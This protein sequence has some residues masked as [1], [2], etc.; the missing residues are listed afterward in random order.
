MTCKHCHTWN[1][2]DEP[3]CVRCSR[4]LQDARPRPAPETYPLATATAPALESLQRREAQLVAVPAGPQVQAHHQPSLFGSPKVIP[5]PRLIPVRSAPRHSRSNEDLHAV[6]SGPRNA[7]RSVPRRGND[8]QQSLDFLSSRDLAGTMTESAAGMPPETVI[9]CNA[10]VAS[11]AHRMIAAA[12]DLGLVLVSLGL[13]V[14]VFVLFGGSLALGRQDVLFF[15]GLALVI[16]IFYRFLWCL[17]SGDTPGMRFAGLQL[18]NFDG[19]PPDRDQRSI[20]Q[21]ASLVSLLS[22]GLGLVWALVDEEGLTWH[23]HISK[24]FPTH[25]FRAQSRG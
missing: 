23:D 12:V 1:E 24:T 9:A 19:N 21:V 8:S 14:T 20:R 15:G 17:A 11:P 22:V 18:V 6:R 3:R 25:S 2:T 13:F 16:G 4:R 10:P 5:I 7:P